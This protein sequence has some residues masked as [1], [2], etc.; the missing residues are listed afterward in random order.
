MFL[1]N[2][3]TPHMDIKKWDRQQ[4][5]DRN[6]S[7]L[8]LKFKSDVCNFKIRTRTQELYIMRSSF[9]ICAFCAFGAGAF[10]GFLAF[11]AFSGFL[12][13]TAFS[14][15]PGFLPFLEA[16]LW[17]FFI[18]CLMIL[19]LCKKKRKRLHFIRTKRVRVQILC[20]NSNSKLS[21]STSFHYHP[22]PCTLFE[23]SNST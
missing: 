5:S 2:T 22:L 13:F 6:K 19:F 4:L 23:M 12:P 3:R 16:I 21:D 1:G 7:K 9:Y 20:L 8:R 11:G 15:F 14:G 10:S 17:S 18:S